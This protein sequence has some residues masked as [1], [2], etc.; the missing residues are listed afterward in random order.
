MG[1]LDAAMAALD[2]G[3]EVLRRRP[4]ASVPFPGL[5]ALV[6]TLVDEGGEATRAE[7]AELPFDTPVSRLILV[8]AEAVALGRGGQ[9]EEATARFAVADAGLARSGYGFRR[10]MIRLLVATDAHRDG[11]GEPAAWLRE[12]LA[13][14]EST[15]LDV[16]AGR[17]RRLL[18]ELGAPVPRR[19]RVA[20]SQVVPP[21]LAERG[22][23]ARE[24]DVLVL[25]AGGATNREVA[26]RL[27][28]SLRTVDK[29]V[30]RL[31]Q[32]TGATRR[33]LAAIG[34]DAG[35]LDT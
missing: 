2:R 12:S 9:S 33:G 7:V 20:V 14:F 21:M 5:W 1:D 35:L 24:V 13:S 17:S 19:S 22:V 4:A 18:R 31:L 11:W 10:P 3:M 34:R 26:E 23:T 25:V 16:L 30:E 6:H 29:H 28:I 27:F 15:G 32:K 8:A